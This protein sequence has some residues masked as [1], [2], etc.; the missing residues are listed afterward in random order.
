MMK[1]LNTT[2]GPLHGIARRA[3][4]SYE[5]AELIILR[6]PKPDGARALSTMCGIFLQARLGAMADALLSM[7]GPE[8]VD[9]LCKEP[10][11]DVVARVTRHFEARFIERAGMD[12]DMNERPVTNI[13]RAAMLAAVRRLKPQDLAFLFATRL[14]SGAD[15]AANVERPAS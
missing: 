10:G 8:L 9:A 2:E 4:E 14:L 3:L 11:P 1:E 15:G 5:R 6:A 13:E 12:V 7:S